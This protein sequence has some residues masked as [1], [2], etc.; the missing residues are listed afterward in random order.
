VNFHSLENP[1][2]H[3]Q[4]K[5]L[6]CGMTISRRSYLRSSAALLGTAFAPVGELGAVS[7]PYARQG[8]RLLVGLAAYSFRDFFRSMKGV[9]NKKFVEGGPEMDMLSFL[10]YCAKH[11]VAG[12]ELTSYFFPQGFDDAYLAECRLHA[13][14][15]GLAISGTA[16][17]NNFSHPTDSP[18]RAEQMTYVKDWID[19]ASIMGAPHIRVFAGVPPKGISPEEAEP[20]AIAALA[21][22]AEY[23]G[24]KGILLGIENHDSISTAERLLRIVQA[25]DS[26]WVGVNLDSGNFKADDV[27]AE[28]AASVPFAVNV[29]LKTEMK[30]G[31]KKVP[32]DLERIVKSIRDGGYS[33]FVTLEFEEAADPYEDVPKWLDKLHEWCA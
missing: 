16:V 1:A 3:L 21:E 22:A 2:S 13:H 26:P 32:A 28:F 14:L 33:G 4:K 11:G 27:Y 15:N 10:D 8:G 5:P 19:K 31:D 23:A 7:Q 6:P 25:V 29:Q 24:S 18:E 30:E 17:G 9:P 20:Y 12:A